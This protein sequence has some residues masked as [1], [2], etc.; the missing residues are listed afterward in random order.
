MRC[1]SQQEQ[2]VCP[3]TQDLGERA[4]ERV[5][6]R[7]RPAHTHT[8]VRF[9]DDDDVVVAA[10]EILEDALLLREID[11]DQSEGHVVERIRPEFIAVSDALELSGIEDLEA[12]AEALPKLALPLRQQRASR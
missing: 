3:L 5:V 8:V 2:R 7:V 1:R 12:Q 6:A 4:P 11:R 9:V 10:L